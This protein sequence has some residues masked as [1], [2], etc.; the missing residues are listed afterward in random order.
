MSINVKLIR[1]SFDAIKPHSAEVMEHFFEVL[2]TG[3]PEARGWFKADVS[4]QQKLLLASFSHV[5]EYLSDSK[6]VSDYLRKMGVRIVNHGVNAAHFEW[7][8]ESL[9][10]TFSYYF[11]EQWSEELNASW[12]AAFAFIAKELQAGISAD[13]KKQVEQRREE[14]KASS[15]P[16]L[17][18]QVADGLFKKAIE[19]L[20]N[21]QAMQKAIQDKAF[22]ILT[23]AIESQAKKMISE[24]QKPDQT[25]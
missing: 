25:K 20:M 13:N 12:I 1:E 21:S 18:H 15:L 11:G 10:N 19:D 2:F 8:A 16:E 9:M 4:G 5:V 23:K 14:V 17:A 6:H 22:E 3:H 24:V 7:V